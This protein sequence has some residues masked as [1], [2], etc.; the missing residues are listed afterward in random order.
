MLIEIQKIRRVAVRDDRGNKVSNPDGEGILMEEKTANE[1]IDVGS[2]KSIRPFRDDGKVHRIIDN[3][4]FDGQ[5]CVIY[6]YNNH[7]NEDEPENDSKRNRRT[8][9]VHVVANYNELLKEV[10]EL[11]ARSV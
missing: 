1:A 2:I 9:E 7:P 6:L 5:V 8:S 4:P 11:K 10:N 3:E